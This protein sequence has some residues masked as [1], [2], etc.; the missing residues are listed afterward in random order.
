MTDTAHTNFAA[1]SH[2]QLYAMLQAGD[3]N[4]ARHAAHKWQ[5]TGSG[6]FEQAENLTGELKDFS[7]NWT[8]G[9]A[10]KYHTMITDL[11]G[12][13]RKVAQTAHAMNNLLEDAAD[14][15]VKAKKE[16]PPPV[17]VPDVSPADL[18]LA[19]NPPL[20]PPDSSQATIINAAQQRQQAIANVE[21]QQQAAS[22]A[23]A[24]HSKAIVVMTQLAGEYST[25]EESIPASPN[26]V[27]PPPVTGGGT[28]P[29]GS[30]GSNIGGTP[31]VGVVPG[32]NT[33]P[34]PSDGSTPPTTGQ[35][36]QP[37]KSNP[38]FGDM[39]T[40][41]LAAASA[42][43]FGRF[44]SIMPR[45][46][47][48][49]NGKNDKDKNGEPAGGGAGAAGATAGGAGGGVP[50][51]GGGA[52]SL[53]GGAIGAGGGGGF[54]G[55]GEAPAAFSGLAGDGG[56]GSAM[57]GLAGGAAGAAGAAAAKGAMPMMPMMP[58]GMGA[59]GDMGSGRRIPPWL[60]E[61]E[62]VWGQSS[63]VA[64]AVL[65]EEPEQY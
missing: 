42:A 15:L 6:L 9:A 52:P 63:P 44:G 14:A 33:H 11:V 65:G 18:A 36:G 53:D 59:G 60:V 55:P 30:I 23:S 13:I 1:Y 10:D 28:A 21:A 31:G 41:G 19:V 45:V 34:L 20:L 50:I 26:A 38:L 61:T 49:A 5:S 25:A 32:D 12:G 62:N 57:S 2:Q 24:A 64:P 37:P 17:A 47:A 40:A 27:A 29:G 46:P 22:A 51:G 7:G 48:W 16:M 39:F 56:S 35:P 43:A 3:P 8:G 58:M 54:S 4:T